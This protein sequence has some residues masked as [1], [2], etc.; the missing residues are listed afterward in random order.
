MRNWNNAGHQYHTQI[1][2]GRK[3]IS[4]KIK[5]REKKNLWKDLYYTE[6][7]LITDSPAFHIFYNFKLSLF[8]M[9]IQLHKKARIGNKKKIWSIR[10]KSW[11]VRR[12][13]PC[14]ELPVD[15]KKWHNPPSLPSFRIYCNLI[16]LHHLV[17]PLCSL[18]NVMTSSSLALLCGAG[19]YIIGAA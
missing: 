4:E 2:T 6:R 15:D 10:N 12:K 18:S 11:E 3:K 19:E 14:H 8:S 1:K 5:K 13:W 16:F 7:F 9:W 17:C